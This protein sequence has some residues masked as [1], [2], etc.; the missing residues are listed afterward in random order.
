MP[1]KP[2]CPSLRIQRNVDV[3]PVTQCW[4]WKLSKDRLGYGRMTISMGSRKQFRSES[5]HRYSYEIFNGP[6]PAGMCV[7][8][9]CDNR[10]CC[11]PDHLFIGTQKENIH[12][13]HKKGRGPRGY[14]RKNTIAAL[15]G[16][17]P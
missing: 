8:H 15:Q 13:M 10:S 2:M 6:I 5:A 17:Q 14:R 11:N 12:D 16:A 3:D 7:L 4:N 9:R 1:T